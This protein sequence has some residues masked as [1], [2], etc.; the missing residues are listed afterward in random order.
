MENIAG[1]VRDAT[2]EVFES[3][4]LVGITP[5][6]PIDDGSKKIDS[7]IS[8]MIGLGGDL[9]GMVV[10]H[11][12]EE[13]AKMITSAML[14]TEVEFIDADVK[15]ALGEIANMV[16]GGMKVFFAEHGCNVE[17]AIPSTVIG[18]GVRMG[19]AVGSKK[20]LV[21]FFTDAGEFGVELNYVMS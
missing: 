3:M 17:L 11:C 15:D 19:S 16:A 8:S 2:V 21:P 10:V 9:K 13:V 7:I 1:Y 14:G 20:L 5:G 12:P 4:V 6:V 18:R